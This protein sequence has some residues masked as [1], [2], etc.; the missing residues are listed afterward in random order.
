MAKVIL[1]FDT[2][3]F[4][5][6]NN[7]SL[8][9]NLN[10]KDYFV[11]LWTSFFNTNISNIPFD[12]YI[13]GLRNGYKPYR[14][15]RMYLRKYNFNILGL[16]VIIIDFEKN[17]HF[18]RFGYDY[19]INIANLIQIQNFNNQNINVIDTKKLFSTIKEFTTNFYENKLNIISEEIMTQNN[20][21]F[22]LNELLLF[23][24]NSENITKKIKKYSKPTV[25]TNKKCVL[26]VSSSFFSIYHNVDCKKFQE[27]LQY[28]FVVVWMNNKN[29]ND[30]QVMN[31]IQKMKVQ[32]ITI[33]FMLFGLNNSIKSISFIKKQLKPT[34]LPFIIIDDLRNIYNKEEDIHMTISCDFDYYIILSEYLVKYSYYDMDT[35]L[36]KI[37]IYLESIFKKKNKKKLISYDKLDSETCDENSDNNCSELQPYQ[38]TFSDDEIPIKKY[39]K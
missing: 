36:N 29:V 17:F 7:D 25:S 35:I 11:M 22:T 30:V 3:I 33:N 14:Y 27:F 1:V 9:R 6:L 2:I 16:P 39:K 20:A 28:C 4:E 23:Y 10:N 26:V 21:V 31:F 15:L 13:N 34:K 8:T 19:C 37:Y 24:K 5:S 12:G 32:K 38:V 18:S